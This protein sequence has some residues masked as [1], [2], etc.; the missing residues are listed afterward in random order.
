MNKTEKVVNK[1]DSLLNCEFEPV[2]EIRPLTDLPM[3]K[4]D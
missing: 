2:F 3:G 4:G 1:I